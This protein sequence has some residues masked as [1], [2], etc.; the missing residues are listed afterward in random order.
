MAGLAY[1]LNG[2]LAW[3]N[4]TVQ[5]AAG[6]V[7]M[8]NEGVVV[9]LKDS[10]AATAVTLPPNPGNGGQYPAVLIIDGKG[11]AATN[12]ITVTASSGNINGAAS[13]VISENYGAVLYFYNGTQWQV[14]SQALSV[15][16]G[17]LAFINGVTAGTGLASKALVLDANGDV[18]MPDLGSIGFGGVA[19]VSW[20]STDAN[21]NKLLV[22]LPAGGGTDVPVIVIGQSIEAVDL[23]LYNGVVDPRVCLMGV[24]AVTT[25]PGLDLRK[26][27]G[28]AASP[29]VV[30]TGDDLGTIRAYGCVAAGEY[31]QAAEIRFDMAGTIATTRG[32]GTITFLTATDAAPSVLTAA[33]TISAAQLVTCAAGLT[34]T[35]GSV[36]ITS[37]DLTLTAASDINVAANTAVALEVDDGTT[38]VTAWDTR[39][40]LKDIDTVTITGV[41]VTVAS[42]TAAHRNA[43]LHLAAKTITYTGTTGTTSSLGTMLY[44]GVPTLTDA[45]AMTLTTASAV[46]I[47]AVAAAGGMLTIS[48]SRMI[49]TS[50]SDCFL[51]NA[52][53]WTDSSCWEEVKERVERGTDKARELVARVIAQLTPATW[54]YRD[55]FEATLTDKSGERVERLP[56]DDRGRERVGIVYNDLP[57]ELRA[58]GEERAVSAGLLSSFALAA[59]KTLWDRNAELESRLAKLEAA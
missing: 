29:T 14:A 9:V 36:T 1:A 30:T 21:A 31:V 46:H 54:R 57:D 4:V 47:N 41:P 33:L 7:T 2:R 11:D 56:L 55:T 16:A 44:V 3:T 15:S 48:N 49:S 5:T 6:D 32:P 42:E 53:A 8:V 19:K 40:T 24:G 18:T 10:G 59:I 45:S 52:G 12:N 17:E 50:V 43:S 20:D 26:A 28:T 22:Q 25:G 38:K 39:N 37:G 58:P 13:H 27:R 34:V 35:T 51:T 23:G